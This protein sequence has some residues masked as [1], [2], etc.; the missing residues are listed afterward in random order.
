E[1]IVVLFYTVTP[2]TL[3][4]PFAATTA[5]RTHTAHR[6]PPKYRSRV[7]SRGYAASSYC[8]LCLRYGR[9]RIY[10]LRLRFSLFSCFANDF[11]LAFNRLNGLRAQRCHRAH[12]AAD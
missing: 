11:A 7:S 8:P 12:D 1:I 4:V 2:F 9:D 3:N 6:T 5:L 10:L